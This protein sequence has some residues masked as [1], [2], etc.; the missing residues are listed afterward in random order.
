[1]DL[2]TEVNELLGRLS[3][4]LHLKRLALDEEDHCILLFDDKVIL[5]MELDGERSQLIVYAYL[6]MVP[7]EHKERI[8][9]WLLQANYFWHETQGS[10]LALDRQTQTLVILRAFTLPLRHPENFEDELGVFVESA[11]HW[12]QQLEDCLARAEEAAR[13]DR[14]H[15]PSR[16]EV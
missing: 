16:E 8:Y 14:E 15:G 12:I 9:E 4:S 5:N 2:K 6:G 3:H 13:Y 1:M 7:I 11:E 10:T